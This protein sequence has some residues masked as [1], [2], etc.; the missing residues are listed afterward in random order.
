MKREWKQK[1]TFLFFARRRLKRNVTWGNIGLVD[2]ETL[3]FANDGEH[4]GPVF[5]S[6]LIFFLPMP[7]LIEGR[8][9]GRQFVEVSAP[10]SRQKGRE[11]SDIWMMRRSESKSKSCGT[12]NPFMI[13]VFTSRKRR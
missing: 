7:V 1:R 4:F 9:V 2:A 8:E 13:E 5:T 10:K 12:A 6:K 3:K 11:T